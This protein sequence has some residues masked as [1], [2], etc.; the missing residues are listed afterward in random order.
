MKLLLDTHLL[1]WAMGEPARLGPALRELL[2]DPRHTLCFS[3]ASLWELVIKAS[4]ARE[5]FQVQPFLLRRTLLD[6]GFL[7]IPITA[8]HVLALGSLPPL[9]RDPFDRLL[10]A[11]AE[12]EGLLLITADRTVARYPGPGRHSDSF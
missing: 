8:D 5:G 1:I 4:L 3:V 10:L 6:G 9:H 2:E 7:E 12:R 11:Q